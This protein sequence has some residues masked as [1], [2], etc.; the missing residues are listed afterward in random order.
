MF[1]NVVSSGGVLLTKTASKSMERR[2]NATQGVDA[3]DRM[4][5]LMEF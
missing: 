3:R 1:R 5:S 4:D 2:V